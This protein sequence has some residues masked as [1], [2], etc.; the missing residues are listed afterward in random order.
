MKTFLALTTGFLSGA[1]AG[2]V[3]MATLAANRERREYDEVMMPTIHYGS[4]EKEL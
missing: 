4:K 2:M 3:Y 1:F